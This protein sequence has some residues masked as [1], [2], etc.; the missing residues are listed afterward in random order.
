MQVNGRIVN[1]TVTEDIISLKVNIC[2]VQREGPHEEIRK[3]KNVHQRYTIL[4]AKNP[5]NSLYCDGKIISTSSAAGLTVTLHS[6][7]I[8]SLVIKAVELRGR[9][10]HIRFTT[11]EE[12]EL[13]DLLNRAAVKESCEPADILYRL[14]TYK[15]KKDGKIR[16]GKRSIYKLSD[17]QTKVVFDKLRRLLFAA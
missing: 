11:A 6:P 8:I 7:V 10:V 5:E 4:D 17:A 15:N 3:L 1:I 14:T 13:T 16:E 9:P 2:D 12:K